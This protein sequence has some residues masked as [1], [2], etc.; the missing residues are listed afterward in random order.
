DMRK[1]RRDGKSWKKV[2]PPK[3]EKQE[4][5]PERHSKPRINTWE[6]AAAQ[7]WNDSGGKNAANQETRQRN[8]TCAERNE[9]A[10][11]ESVD[12]RTEHDSDQSAFL[13]KRTKETRRNSERE[14]GV[15]SD[16]P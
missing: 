1:A 8:D 5:G 9:A 2:S 14:P 11:A 12:N 13:I 16:Q 3:A 7:Q 4:T 10:K 15:G 6:I